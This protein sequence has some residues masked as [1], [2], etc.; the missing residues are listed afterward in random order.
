[1]LGLFCAGSSDGEL[2]PFLHMEKW[3]RS[4]G[5]QQGL[6]WQWLHQWRGREV[7]EQSTTGFSGRKMASEV[8]RVSNL[9]IQITRDVHSKVAGLKSSQECKSVISGLRFI[10][11]HRHIA[12]LR[13]GLRRKSWHRYSSYQCSNKKKVLTRLLTALTYTA[14]FTAVWIM[15][16]QPP[17]IRAG[18]K[19]G[20]P[21]LGVG[22]MCTEVWHDFIGLL[23]K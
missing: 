4:W 9:V 7:P 1:M 21:N 13:W 2:L 8:S 22:R 14:L 15:A 18:L 6:W 10:A 23:D 20:Q 16:E 19:H 11:R 3:A 5:W 12:Q 17:H